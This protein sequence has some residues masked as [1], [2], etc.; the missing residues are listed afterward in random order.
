MS[1]QPRAT[2]KADGES[3][4]EQLEERVRQLFGE[5]RVAADSADIHLAAAA[6]ERVRRLSPPEFSALDPEERG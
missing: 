3:A 1:E 4:R 2:G 5:E 6:L